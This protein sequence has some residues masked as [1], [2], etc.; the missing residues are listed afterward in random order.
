MNPTKENKNGTSAQASK[1]M[2]TKEEKLINYLESCI[3]YE[4]YLE[5]YPKGIPKERWR[6]FGFLIKTFQT[7]YGWQSNRIGLFA[8]FEEWLRG[9][10]TCFTIAFNYCD[11]IEKGIEIGYLKE[12]A[13]E[14]EKDKFLENWFNF[15][16]MFIMKNLT[17]LAKKN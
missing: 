6:K 9:L 17:K 7:E 1:S 8:A 12:N 13:T 3:D 2:L 10:P 5:N 4:G 16:T 11:I 14:D 15:I